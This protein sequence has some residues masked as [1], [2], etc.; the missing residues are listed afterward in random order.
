MMRLRRASVIAALSLLTSAATASAQDEVS[1]ISCVVSGKASSTFWFPRPAF[2][3]E[4]WSGKDP[5][6]DNPN[7]K[8]YP[9]FDVEVPVGR[10]WF[11]EFLFSKLDQPNPIVRPVFADRAGVGG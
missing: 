3:P 11:I 7:K 6:I 1:S 4:S 8:P 2:A 10:G 9:H 5:Y